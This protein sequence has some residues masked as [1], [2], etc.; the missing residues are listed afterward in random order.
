MNADSRKPPLPLPDRL[1]SLIESGRWPTTGAAVRIQNDEPIVPVA[2][3]QA[4]A[5]GQDGLC[6][7]R[8]PFRTVAEDI[9]RVPSLADYWSEFGAI[10][11]LDPELA[12]IIADFGLGSDTPI[13]LDYRP[14]DDPQ[15]LTIQWSS[16]EG[17]DGT[18]RAENRW[19]V[20]AAS[21]DEF[22]ERLGLNPA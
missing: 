10:E 4:L 20:L 2:R 11:Q 18:R 13:L 9:V 5:P 21:F 8:P 16:V 14:G 17:D 12:L 3:I 15:V 19:I 1:A 7:Y 22:V 6:L